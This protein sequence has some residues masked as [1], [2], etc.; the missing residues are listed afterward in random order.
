MNNLGINI[1]KPT[2]ERAVFQ[3]QK[4]HHSP[5]TATQ[6]E[7]TKLSVSNIKCDNRTLGTILKNTGGGFSR[8]R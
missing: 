1:H 4:L 2:A 6:G 5:L 3:Q 8:F 7:I